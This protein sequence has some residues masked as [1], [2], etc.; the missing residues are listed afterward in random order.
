MS[1]HDREGSHPSNSDAALERAWRET[2]DEQPPAHLDAAII[3]AA[4]KSVPDRGE[5]PITAPVHV[6]SRSW[7]TQWQPLAAAVA[8]TGRRGNGCGA[9]IR[10][11]PDVAA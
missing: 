3:A 5:Q 8:A 6:Q 10:P 1:N 7:L 4:R 2:S 11:G 9:R